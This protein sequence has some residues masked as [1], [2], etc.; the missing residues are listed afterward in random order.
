MTRIL[1]LC[2]A[3]KASRLLPVLRICI[4]AVALSFW[5][6]SGVK[7]AETPP[8]GAVVTT[9][10]A[11]WSVDP[12]PATGGPVTLAPRENSVTSIDVGRQLFFDDYLI[13]QTTLTRTMHTP[14]LSEKN[15]VLKAEADFE[16]ND[17]ATAA[18]FKDGVWYDPSDHLFKMWYK[19]GM[20]DG[21]CYAES[22]DGLTWKRPT[23]DVVPGTNRVLPIRVGE[24]GK[25]LLRDAATIWLDDNA[26]SPAERFKMSVFNRQ[27]IE[28][29]DIGK[30][31][32]YVSPDGIHWT[33][34]PV[35]KGAEKG[36]PAGWYGG[37]NSSYYYDP[38]R[39]LWVA[40]IRERPQTL[41]A[42]REKKYPPGENKIAKE[43]L[44]IAR[45]Y[46]ARADW[47]RL[48]TERR[49]SE[50]LPPGRLPAW[51]YADEMDMYADGTEGRVS[52]FCANAYE[53]VMLGLLC[54]SHER[55]KTGERETAPRIWDLKLAFSRDAYH[56][57]RPTHE[58]FLAGTLK[59]GD[60]NCGYLHPA[61]GAWL[62]VGDELW[63]YFGAWSGESA[64]GSSIYAGGSTGLAKLRRDGFF[65]MDAAGQ[66]G[67]LTTT[68]VSFSGKYPFVNVNASGGELQAE[69]LDQRGEVI[70]PYTLKNSVAIG[71]DGAK[72]RLT[73][74]GAEDLSKLSGQPVRF[75]FTMKHGSL[76]SFWVSPDASGASHGY[77]AA[78]GPGFTGPK[79]T[80]SGHFEGR[81]P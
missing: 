3:R 65:S 49:K 61:S 45:Y 59:V 77:V 48:F 64:K 36:D 23:L 18:P 58:N 4:V 2:S 28:P 44:S 33:N 46:F 76:Y 53:S 21:T 17:L 13:S 7:A 22:K 11:P 10:T 20:T 32:I 71:G 51:L 29:I 66:Q 26:A 60:W 43:D 42:L 8:N 80:T 35:P 67:T 81:Q 39:K 74:R 62:L 78:G 15:P 54:I 55:P 47:A 9:A 68:P 72:Q 25:R 73:W 69:V 12:P 38:F 63:F 70:E 57:E 40:D 30:N 50:V 5:V 79:D 6:N 34:I 1:Q 56:W 52:D 41:K 31:E 75:R 14:V 16:V 19:G 27:D 37:D 24:N